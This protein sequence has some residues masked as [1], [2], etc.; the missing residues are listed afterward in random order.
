[1]TTPRQRIVDPLSVSSLLIEVA[2]AGEALATAT[3]FVVQPHETPFLITNWHV[4]AGRNAETNELLSATGAEPQELRILHHYTAQLGRWSPLTVPLHPQGR[5]AWLEHPAGRAVDVVA[6][7]LQTLPPT[8]QLYPLDLALAEVDIVVQVAMP[9][10]IIG[11]PFGLTSQGAL[12]IWKAGH[13]ASDPDLDYGER[14]AFL[15][16]ATTRSGMSGSPVVHRSFG[17][18]LDSKGNYNIATGVQTRLLGV[19]SGRIHDQSEIGRVWRP[20][21]ILQILAAAGA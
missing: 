5:R 10:S 1:M 7:P 18:Y 13:I 6:F 16:D 2:A 21:L 3:G 15:I 17:S 20:E 4:V 9:V 8:V 11:F 14:P 19:Y 12:P